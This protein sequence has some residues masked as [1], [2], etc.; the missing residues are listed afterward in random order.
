MIDLP[1]DQRCTSVRAAE[2]VPEARCVAAAGHRNH[3]M[4]G[5]GVKSRT[6][7]Q[8]TL[9]DCGDCAAK[10]GRPHDSGCDVEHCSACGGQWIACGCREHD[11]IF[12][13]WSGVYP[14]AAEAA[15]LGIDLN[16][17]HRRDYP[18][19]FFVKPSA[20]VANAV[21]TATAEVER[22]RAERIKRESDYRARS[23]EIN[24]ERNARIRAMQDGTYG[25]KYGY[26]QDE[27]VADREAVAHV[28][29][30]DADSDS[31]YDDR[32]E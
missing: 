23:K 1:D 32:G 12:A 11:P 19:V 18:R 13:R 4:E 26:R 22:A 31:R 20:N 8:A 5:W 29:Y 24:D 9:H 14:G 30:S 21:E 27:E 10:P 6:W 3:H 15:Y 17:F 28:G 25:Q 16:E 2:S 7:G